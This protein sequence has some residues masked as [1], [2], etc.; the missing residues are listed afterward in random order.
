MIKVLEKENILTI[1]MWSVFRE[2]RNELAHEYPNYGQIAEN[3]NF[4]MENSD[5]L[6]GISSKLEKE[7]L[8][9]KEL[10]NETIN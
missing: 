4:I 2:T 1:D 3:I 7:F 8:K 9:I 6:I 10:K 5:E